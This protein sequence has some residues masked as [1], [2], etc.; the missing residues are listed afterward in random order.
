[1]LPATS[2]SLQA[3][4]VLFFW[5]GW[6]WLHWQNT[7]IEWLF[8]IAFSHFK[9]SY[10]YLTLCT[11]ATLGFAYSFRLWI[12]VR[13][14]V[15]HIL[16]PGCKT[17]TVLYCIELLFWSYSA[18]VFIVSS[19]ISPRSIYQLY[20][21]LHCRD[22]AFMIWS[23]SRW[24]VWAK[25]HYVVYSHAI[26]VDQRN[27]GEFRPCFFYVQKYLEIHNTCSFEG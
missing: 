7:T 24:F 16:Q 21:Q 19:L 13:G 8:Q 1:M 6:K 14:C 25:T 18:H 9:A 17:R 10:W 23:D 20:I 15:Q 11:S 2:V 27:A 4:I 12:H 5:G 26:G 3:L 22:Y